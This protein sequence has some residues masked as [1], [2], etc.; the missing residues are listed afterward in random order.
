MQEAL[1]FEEYLRKKLG[2][3][4]LSSDRLP[5]MRVVQLRNGHHICRVKGLGPVDKNTVV[6]NYYQWGPGTVEKYSLLNA[7]VVSI[8]IFNI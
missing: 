7:L 8:L 3:Q 1:G 6:T 5:A 2:C 4:P